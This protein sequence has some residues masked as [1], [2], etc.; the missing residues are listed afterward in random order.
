MYLIFRSPLATPFSCYSSWCT[1][2][3]ENINEINKINNTFEK[4]KQELQYRISCLKC[5]I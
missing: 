1:H 4:E 3:G 2:L 5:N